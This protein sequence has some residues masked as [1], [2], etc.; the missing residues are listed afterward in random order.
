MGNVHKTDKNHNNT[1]YTGY[2]GEVWITNNY[3]ANI[4]KRLSIYSGKQ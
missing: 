1:G 3:Q 4:K 2:N